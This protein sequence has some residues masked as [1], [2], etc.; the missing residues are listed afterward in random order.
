MALV[1]AATCS[2]RFREKLLGVGV[3]AAKFDE[4]R[5][6][7]PVRLCSLDRLP[8]CLW[9]GQCLSSL[10]DRTPVPTLEPFSMACPRT[11][12]FVPCQARHQ[13]LATATQLPNRAL[14]NSRA[15]TL[16]VKNRGTPK[17]KPHKPIQGLKPVVWWFLP[18]EQGLTF[19]IPPCC[20]SARGGQCWPAAGSLPARWADCPVPSRAS[21]EPHQ[22]KAST[23]G[24]WGGRK[25]WVGGG[26]PKNL[27]DF[28][29][30][31]SFHS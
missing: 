12:S 20:W 24:A 28:T 1:A 4:A 10:K 7:Y 30:L 13:A 31:L 17:W 27:P 23:H 2:Q 19:G 14:W 6:G 16:C 18:P 3:R 9:L 5:Q 8:P 25:G 15:S 21:A 26:S 29:E 11:S 22:G